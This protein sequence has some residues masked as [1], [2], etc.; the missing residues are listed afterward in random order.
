[1][2]KKVMIEVNPLYL[3]KLNKSWMFAAAA[4]A[5]VIQSEVTVVEVGS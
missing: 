1:M 2:F 4:S 3:F 5:F